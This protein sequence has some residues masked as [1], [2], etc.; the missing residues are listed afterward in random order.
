MTMDTH[1]RFAG[2]LRRAAAL[3]LAAVAAMAGCGGGV[4]V[5]GTGGFASGP[6]TG[7]GSVI[8][9]GIEFDDAT[10]QVEDE[11]GG[12]SAP[13]VLQLGMVVDVD[14]GPIGGSAAAPTAVAAHIRFGSEIVGPVDSVDMAAA[15]LGVFGQTVAVTSTT[16]FDSRLTN[17]LASVTVGSTLEVFGAFDAQRS[18]FV[19]TRIAPRDSAVAFFKVRGPVRNLDP[20]A[21]TFA[22]GSLVL[23][24]TAAPAG[25]AEGVIVRVRVETTPV[26]GTWTVH[27]FG[28]GV[29]SLPDLDRARLRGPITTFSSSQQFSVDG[30]PVDA[31]AASFPD[32]TAGLALGVEVDVEGPV[33][34]G[35]LRATQVEI[36][37]NGGP[38]GG[39]EL[40]GSIDEHFPALQLFALRG[41]TVFYGA[42]GVEFDNGTATDLRV[43]VAVEARGVLSAN[44][45]RLLATRIR[46]KN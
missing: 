22:I 18:R 35:V 30:Q 24:Y 8:V 25:L 16:V 37:D 13:G 3:A 29:R 2:L 42:P 32:G 43:G 36:D 31:S 46:F 6:I 20:A 19:A 7:F 17:G 10:A 45:T 14:S 34:G 40:K 38:Q 1:A 5:G 21:R 11:D 33:A 39:F 44:G 23:R 15:S 4:G 12:A 41:V 27:A 26:A 28:A 9:N